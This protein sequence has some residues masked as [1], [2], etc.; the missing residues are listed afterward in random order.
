MGTDFSPLVEVQLQYFFHFRQ[1]MCV[2]TV[3]IK[4]R[5]VLALKPFIGE[6]SVLLVGMHLQFCFSF[7]IGWKQ[8]QFTKQKA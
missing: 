4:N 1:Q 6:W 2:V 8:M 5:K 3:I 7:S